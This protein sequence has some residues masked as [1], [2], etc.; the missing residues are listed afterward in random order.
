MQVGDYFN[1]ERRELF[2]RSMSAFNENDVRSDRLGGFDIV[3]GVA[4][5]KNF[6]VAYPSAS[7]RFPA[8]SNN[9]KGE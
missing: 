1:A 6:S 5:K 3:F 2:V 8:C 9:Q 7:W 4:D